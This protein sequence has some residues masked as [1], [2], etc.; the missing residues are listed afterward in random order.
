MIAVLSFG[1]HLGVFAV[2]NGI[3]ISEAVVGVLSLFV[4]GRISIFYDF[5][6]PMY[7]RRQVLRN[8]SAARARKILCIGIVALVVELVGLM[9]YRILY[10]PMP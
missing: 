5:N 4:I 6:S 7:M 2:Q 3:E 1:F 10:L 8:G 9:V